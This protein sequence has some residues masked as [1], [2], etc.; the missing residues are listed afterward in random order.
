MTAYA[1][2]VFELGQR[3][4]GSQ[5]TQREVYD[6]LAKRRGVDPATLY[7]LPDCPTECL[8]L[9]DWFHQVR[10]C[11]PLTFQ[12][13]AAWDRLTGAGI[14]PEEVGVL[15]SLDKTLLAVQAQKS[16]G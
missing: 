12:E 11:E 15:M 7:K 14:T 1:R 5:S 10:G 16:P 9:L 4:E 3:V 2:R 13:V 8:Y 6:T